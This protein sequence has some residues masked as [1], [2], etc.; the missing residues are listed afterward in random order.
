MVEPV[1]LNKVRKARKRIEKKALAEANSI[2]FGRTNAEK[3]LAKAQELKSVTRLS[4]HKIE[5]D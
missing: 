3:T 4:Q 5:D 2:K 1:N